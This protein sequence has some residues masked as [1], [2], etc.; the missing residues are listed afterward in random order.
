MKTQKTMA[1]IL[2]STLIFSMASVVALERT[3]TSDVNLEIATEEFTDLRKG[4]LDEEALVEIIPETYEL[5]EAEITEITDIVPRRFILWTHD[6]ENV[7]W[8][9]YG[10]NHFVGEDNNGKKA[11]GIYYNGFFAGF[12]DG[13]FF[14][15]K[16]TRSRWK[17]VGLFG[18]EES[19][20]GFL[21]FPR[22]PT[23]TLSATK[24]R[25]I[26]NRIM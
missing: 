25:H 11:W 17:A 24:V 3:R 23:P 22:K 18:E 13:D 4:N 8:G 12:Y 6:G 14:H 9:Q 15:G 19:H 5:V 20:G 21:T 1:V 16:Y 2:L 26:P 10:R 7:M